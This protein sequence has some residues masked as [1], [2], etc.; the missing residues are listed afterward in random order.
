MADSL[1]SVMLPSMKRRQKNL[2]QEGLIPGR[3]PYYLDQNSIGQRMLANLGWSQGK[4]LGKNENG[5]TVPVSN[6]LKLDTMG[7]GFTGVRDDLWTQHDADFNDLL[8]RL[9]GE[10]DVPADTEIDPKSQLQ[11]LEQKSKNSR[12]RVHYNKFTRGKDLSRANEKDLASIFG[13]R[14]VADK[15]VEPLENDSSQNDSD[16]D[17]QTARPILG[18]STIKASVSMH[19]YFQEKMKQKKLSTNGSG[20]CNGPLATTEKEAEKDP[21]AEEEHSSAGTEKRKTKKNRKNGNETGEVEEEQLSAEKDKCKTK[22]SKKKYSEIEESELVVPVEDTASEEVSHK[23]SKRKREKMEQTVNT[24]EEVPLEAENTIKKKKK[25]HKQIADPEPDETPE[26]VQV[27]Q[28]VEVSA[29]DPEE[30]AKKKKKSKRSKSVV[31]AETNDNA[32]PI[33]D[34]NVPDTNETAPIDSSEPVK[35]KKKS[36]KSK[37]KSGSSEDDNGTV[38]TEL[39]STE[40][41]NDTAHDS[42][43]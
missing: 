42:E 4:G 26:V 21:A 2:C 30:P 32:E 19:E 20:H 40:Q 33:E 11:S 22:K 25:S 38:G 17:S 35:K 9:N 16:D 28:A 6:K 31:S 41:I 34:N 24:M 29:N 12:V 18:L 8:Q 13:K 23:K 7:V 39:K 14:A 15:P 10:E 27:E 3:R 36:K 43:D 5:I 37:V 1:G